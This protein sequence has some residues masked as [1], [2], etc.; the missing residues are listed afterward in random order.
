MILLGVT[1]SKGSAVKL[2]KST[3]HAN[4]L[5]SLLVAHEQSPT[6][7]VL[8]TG[9]VSDWFTLVIVKCIMRVKVG[10]VSR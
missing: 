8:Y 9:C 3:E 2:S 4:A 10:A 5:V 7:L 1:P 6:P